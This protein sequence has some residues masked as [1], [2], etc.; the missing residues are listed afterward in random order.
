MLG[1]IARGYQKAD[2]LLLQLLIST[3]LACS[4]GIENNKHPRFLCNEL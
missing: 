1:W 3:A 2:L 4:Q